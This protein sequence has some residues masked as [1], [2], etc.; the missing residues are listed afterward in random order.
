MDAVFFGARRA[1]RVGQRCL[2]AVPRGQ[3]VVAVSHEVEAGLER[4]VAVRHG[5]TIY[6]RTG[7]VVAWAALAGFVLTLGLAFTRRENVRS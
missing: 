1:P 6:G 4:E 3:P 2:D 5:P 7:D